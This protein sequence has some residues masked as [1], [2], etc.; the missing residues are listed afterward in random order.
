MVRMSHGSIRGPGKAPG[1]PRESPARTCG[2]GEQLR[3]PPV[4][5]VLS[6]SPQ[7][8][9]Q[10]ENNRVKNSKFRLE[11]TEGERSSILENRKLGGSRLVEHVG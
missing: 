9:T 6:W 10:L 8:R 2:R 5:S 3:P 4:P 1:S 7:Q 11:Y